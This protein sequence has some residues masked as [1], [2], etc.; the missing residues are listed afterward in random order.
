VYSKNI[1]FIGENYK[2]GGE[3]VRS[4]IIILDNSMLKTAGF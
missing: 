1:K 4:A 3:L 2:K